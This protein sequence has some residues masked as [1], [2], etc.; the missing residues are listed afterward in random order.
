MAAPGEIER[1]VRARLRSLR[2]TL[3]L[4][5]DELAAR[6]NLSASTISPPGMIGRS[7]KWPA[8]NGSLIVTA[9]MAVILSSGMSSS[10]RST[11]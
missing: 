5:L 4:S 1:V 10:T 11:P 8:K 3:G 9:L 7:G 2:T 6:T